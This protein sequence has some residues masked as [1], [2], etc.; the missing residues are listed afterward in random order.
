MEWIKVEDRLPE[1]YQVVIICMTLPFN[2]T[3]VTSDEYN[4]SY[5]VYAELIMHE[6]VTHWMS[7][8][9]PPKK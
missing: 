5:W 6:K 8:P 1:D 7:L 2:K 4:G 9:E 3:K